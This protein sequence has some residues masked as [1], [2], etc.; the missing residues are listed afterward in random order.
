MVCMTKRKARPA[1]AVR[2]APILSNQ[3]EASEAARP[4]ADTGPG[5]AYG[6]ISVKRF[7][8]LFP[9]CESTFYK[10]VREG[11]I[12][13]VK[14]GPK[15]LVPLEEVARFRASLEAGASART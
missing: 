1:V 8:E 6:C 5:A 10:A 3:Q 7:R 15:T 11:R 14:W 13:V 2:A 4:A 12:R 9:S